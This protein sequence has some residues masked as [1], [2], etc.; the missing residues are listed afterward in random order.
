MC[1]GLSISNEGSREEVISRIIKCQRKITKLQ[2]SKTQT[3]RSNKRRRVTSEHQYSPQEFIEIAPALPVTIDDRFYKIRPQIFSNSSEY[4]WQHT[5]TQ[6]VKIA[7]EPIEVE[8][9]VSVVVK[10]HVGSGKRKM[11]RHED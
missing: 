10:D 4:G 9:K 11:K 6:E 5:G 1:D 2:T 8:V 3:P 7:G